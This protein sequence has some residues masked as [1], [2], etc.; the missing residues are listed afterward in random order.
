MTIPAQVPSGFQDMKELYEYLVGAG[1]S[2]AGTKPVGAGRQTSLVSTA[3]G[4][5]NVTTAVPY[6]PSAGDTFAVKAGTRYRFKT[7]INLSTGATSHTTAWGLTLATA[8]VAQ[9]WGL[10]EAR[11]AADATIG[12]WQVREIQA[13]TA[14]VLTAAS[15]AVETHLRCEG[16]IDFTLGGTIQ[17]FVQFNADPT[18]T[19]QALFGTFFEIWPLGPATR[20]VHGNWS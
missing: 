2:F 15:T 5:G 6:L 10:G 14:T 13:A 20:L 16:V 19:N 3:V 4:L 9:I 1:E 12:A 18:G 17:P 7:F 8:T 11:S